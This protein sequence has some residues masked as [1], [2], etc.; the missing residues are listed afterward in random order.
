MSV[1]LFLNLR[2][3]CTDRLS[4]WNLSIASESSPTRTWISP[5]G[6]VTPPLRVSLVRGGGVAGNRS[7]EP[8]ALISEGGEVWTAVDVKRGDSF[9]LCNTSDSVRT[10]IRA[11][12][13]GLHD[14][15]TH[16]PP[17]P[18]R[19]YVLPLCSRS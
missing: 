6:F 14:C 17:S 1:G 2:V 5:E 4:A 8:T 9:S 19:G 16:K 13:G 18:R 12:S 3:S 15:S 11:M 10:G 7:A